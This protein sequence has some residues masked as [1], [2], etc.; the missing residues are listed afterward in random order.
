MAFSNQFTRSLDKLN[1]L[2][3]GKRP[4]VFAFGFGKMVKL[5][6]TA[7]LTFREV[8]PS[9]VVVHCKNRKRV[10]NHIG[11]VHAAAMALTVESATG[12]VFGQNVPDA[13]L[14]LCKTMNINYK[15]IAKGDV[16]ATATLTDEQI[17]EIRSKEKGEVTV[18]VELVD[19][20]GNVPIEAEL[21]WAWVPKK[22]K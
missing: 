22:R 12:V 20:D 16:T 11:G 18:A 8:S 7:K 15:R 3:E 1:F 4:S 13:C 6:G 17:A 2:P 5:F 10:Q 9:K 21:V 19:A 14:P